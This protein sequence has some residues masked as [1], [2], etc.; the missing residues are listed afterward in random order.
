MSIPVF[1]FLTKLFQNKMAVRRNIDVNEEPSPDLGKSPPIEAKTSEVAAAARPCRFENQASG[2]LPDGLGPSDIVCGRDRLSHAHC[3]N[4]RFRHIIDMN[5]ERYQNAP[6]RDKKTEI[7]CTIVDM[8]HSFGGRFLKL[9]E[10]DGTLKEIDRAS[11]HEKVSHALR[12]AKDKSCPKP[13]KKR[14]IPKY[15]PSPEEDDLYKTALAEQQR[16]YR[17]LIEWEEEGADPLDLG[18]LEKYS[19]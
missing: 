15:V 8:I 11:A 9:D 10:S 19:K 17:Q 6:S 14:V 3:G 7:T 5:R 1:G 13:K 18:A 16:V 12:S 2:T 4:R